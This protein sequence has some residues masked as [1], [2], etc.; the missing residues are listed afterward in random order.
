MSFDGTGYLLIALLLL[1]LQAS[2]LVYRKKAL[3]DISEESL[4]LYTLLFW[5][6]FSAHMACANPLTCINPFTI[7]LLIP[8]LT[9]LYL[10]VTTTR[11]DWSV[12]VLLYI[13][14][15]VVQLYFMYSQILLFRDNGF[16]GESIMQNILVTASISILAFNFIIYSLVLII[17]PLGEEGGPLSK[18]GDLWFLMGLADKLSGKQIKS[19][20][21]FLIILLVAGSFFIFAAMNLSE[22]FLISFWVIAYGAAQSLR[23]R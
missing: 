17:V 20:Y 5:G 23:A 1:S 18:P 4:L 21:A 15:I 13:W 19:S 12:R 8:T 2:I 14:F 10:A 7:L 6:A 11:L 16:L 9:V 3:P 22:Q